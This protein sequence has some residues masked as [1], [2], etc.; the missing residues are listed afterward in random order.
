MNADFERRL[1]SAMDQ[2]QVRPRPEHLLREAHRA[3]RRRL[4]ITRSAAAIAT[5]AAVVAFVALRQNATHSGSVTQPGPQTS[6]PGGQPADP[7][8][9]AYVISHLARA[10]ATTQEMLAAKTVIPAGASLP[11]G[12]PGTWDSWMHGDFVRFSHL[13]ASGNPIEDA[14]VTALTQGSGPNEV[15]VNYPSRQVIRFTKGNQQQGTDFDAS[16]GCSALNG[17]LYELDF[18]V[19][20]PG[21]SNSGHSLLTFLPLLWGDAKAANQQAA[22]VRLTCSAI[23]ITTHEEF[24]GTAAYKIVFRP[25]GFGA[26]PSLD[27]SQTMWVDE[28]TFL[29]IGAQI[30][31]HGTVQETTSYTWLRPTSANLA[32]LNVPIPAGFTHVT[33]S[34]QIP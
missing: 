4:L 10:L 14:G 19:P 25:H 27:A 7:R 12:S 11:G 33:S 6:A 29:P 9:T 24:D 13:D 18:P 22:P 3:H 8:T 26:A 23:T 34:L 15:L 28:S 21:S 30:Q 16:V 20:D 32:L 17:M 31:E 1:K 5:A 2:V